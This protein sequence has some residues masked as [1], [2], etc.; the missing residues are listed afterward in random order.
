MRT[1]PSVSHSVIHSA[2]QMISAT[3]ESTMEWELVYIVIID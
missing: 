1:T 3:N 2:S